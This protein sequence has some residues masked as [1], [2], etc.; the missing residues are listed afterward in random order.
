MDQKEKSDP[1]FDE[2]T[3]LY[4][5]TSK[6]VDDNIEFYGKKNTLS[7]QDLFNIWKN[8]SQQVKNFDKK[9]WTENWHKNLHAFEKHKFEAKFLIH[10]Y[11]V[12]V[13]EELINRL[14]NRYER[15][16]KLADE[17]SGQRLGV[18]EDNLS[19]LIRDEIRRQLKLELAN[20]RR[21]TKKKE[22]QQ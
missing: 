6:T 5:L 2:Y 13:L 18:P 12:D 10:H 4:K 16:V 8:L 20:I 14:V 21:K 17:L 9:D 3:D 15:Y 11:L 7:E 19:H 22:R 1:I